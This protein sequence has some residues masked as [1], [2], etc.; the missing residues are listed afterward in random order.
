VSYNANSKALMAELRAFG[1]QFSSHSIHILSRR[2]L[3]AFALEVT[4][5]KW[6]KTRSRHGQIKNGKSQRLVHWCSA[7]LPSCLHKTTSDH[8]KRF[9]D[10]WRV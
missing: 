8:K 5:R 3:T 2:K 4:S 10:L 7:T 6:T 9:H 1:H